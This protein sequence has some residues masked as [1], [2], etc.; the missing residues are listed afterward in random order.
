MQ[1]QP[2]TSIAELMAMDPLKHSEQDLTAIIEDLRK[3]RARFVLVGDKKVGTPA[4]RKSGA[5]KNREANAAI[6]INMDDLLKD[7]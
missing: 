6:G 7:L 1:D 4:A 3:S 2:Q 5:Q